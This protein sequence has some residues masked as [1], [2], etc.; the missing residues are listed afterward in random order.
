MLRIAWSRLSGRANNAARRDRAVRFV[1]SAAFAVAAFAVPL[2]F[3]DYLARNNS[4]FGCCDPL[5]T[6]AP[7]SFSLLGERG[8]G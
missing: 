8:G 4:T 3:M 7:L 6:P 2:R 1:A 5:I